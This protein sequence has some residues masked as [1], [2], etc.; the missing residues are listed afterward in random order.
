[1]ICKICETLSKEYFKAKVLNKYDVQYYRCPRCSFIQTEK[2][3]WINESYTSA[4]TQLDIG[5]IQRNIELA[6]KTSLIIKFNFNYNK[7]FLDFAGGYGMLTRLMRDNG[8]K[9]FRQDKYCEN[10]FAKSFDLVNTENK[11][12]EIVT[13]FEVFEHLEDP[14]AD[15]DEMLNYSDSILFSTL[16][17]PN[18]EITPEKWWYVSPEMGQHIA[19]YHLNTLKYIAEVKG[20]NL[21]TNKKN[22]H[23]ITKKK[24]NKY[25]FN[26]LTNNI[27]SNFLFFI[28]PFFKKSLNL[29]DYYYL[30][31][32]L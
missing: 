7:I 6:K 12:F 13:A 1:M 19:I 27:I 20:L 9:F 14:M 21:Y 18:Y 8:F 4:I 24:I 10:L 31:N 32:K 3:F 17:Q 25:S 22:I 5:L 26:L 23:L 11:I 16:L 29:E 30:K 28:T 2:P 15:I